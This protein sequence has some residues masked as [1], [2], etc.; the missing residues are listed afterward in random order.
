MWSLGVIFYLLLALI[1]SKFIA[2]LRGRLPFDGNKQEDIIKSIVTGQP[3]YNN[4][5]FINL[6]YNVSLFHSRQIIS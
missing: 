1:A 5:A 6:S 4:S 3:D 2:R